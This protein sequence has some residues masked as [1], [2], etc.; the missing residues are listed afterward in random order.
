MYILLYMYYIINMYVLIHTHIHTHIYMY[1]C[2]Y[3]HKDYDIYYIYIFIEYRH[4]ICM[5]ICL[6]K[7]AT[8]FSTGLH[9]TQTQKTFKHAQYRF[10]ESNI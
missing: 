5:Y 4:M 10:N 8:P 7:M 1:V 2:I 9:M 3:L 6:L